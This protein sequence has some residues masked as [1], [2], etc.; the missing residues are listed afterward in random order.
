MKTFVAQGKAP[1]NSLQK[2]DGMMW[3]VKEK[4]LLGLTG[5]EYMAQ[6]LRNPF[7]WL[8][9]VIFAIGIPVVVAR[10]LFGLSYVTHSCLCFLLVL[11]PFLLI[12][13]LYF[14]RKTQYGYI[15][16]QASVFF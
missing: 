10:F 2:A 9:A 12:P 5:K 13:N 3:T 15:L 1:V 11:L 6:A 4:L 7:N 8:L 16:F 14:I